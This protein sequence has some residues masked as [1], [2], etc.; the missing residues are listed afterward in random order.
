WWH[1][2]HYTHGFLVPLFALA[3]P[4][5]GPTRTPAAAV[6]PTRGEGPPGA[7]ADS[8]TTRASWTGVLMIGVGA[9]VQVVGTYYFVGW[10]VAASML[11]MLAGICT[12]VGGWSLLRRAWPSVAFLVF[13]IPL[14]YRVELALGGP[15]QR[16]ATPL[17]STF[18]LQ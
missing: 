7:P 2:A 10:L 15:L 17:A 3:L 9:L 14:P 12:L 13:M 6:R 16:L 18:V 5:L 11:P 4:W 8:V 1:D